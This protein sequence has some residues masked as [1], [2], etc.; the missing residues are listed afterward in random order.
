M[1]LNSATVDDRVHIRSETPDDQ[2]AIQA[3][4]IAAFG[5]PEEAVLIGELRASGH[6]LA[7]L[8]A[9]IDGCIAGHIMFSR[10][11]IRTQQ[12]L[13]SAVA[14]APLAVLPEHQRRGIGG[15]LIQR[16]LELLRG[17]GEKI[18]IVVGHPA[19]YPK[20][21]FS[22]ELARSLESPF[23]REAFMVIELTPGALDGVRGTVV[24]PAAFGV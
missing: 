9:E 4:N 23:P 17:W 13:V 21:G 10:M 8:V 20:F 16:G 15:V 7:S 22:T 6:A 3:V 12:G 14:L 11:W 5:G 1:S 18:V 2:R 24:Y 19:Y